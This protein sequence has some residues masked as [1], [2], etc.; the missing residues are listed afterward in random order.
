[1]K[2]NKPSK[3][4]IA[5]QLIALHHAEQEAIQMYKTINEARE[6]EAARPRIGPKEPRFLPYVENE[7]FY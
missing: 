5:R 4:E 3:R 7:M 6:A 1:M 2:R